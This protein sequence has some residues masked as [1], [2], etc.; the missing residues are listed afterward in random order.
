VRVTA[1]DLVR[2]SVFDSTEG[3]GMTA[4]LTDLIDVFP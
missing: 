1:I 4:P 2:L 3:D